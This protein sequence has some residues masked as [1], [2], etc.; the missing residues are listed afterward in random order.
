MQVVTHDLDP[1]LTFGDISWLAGLSKLPVLVKGV[2]RADD[3]RRCVEHGAAGIVVSNHGGRQL[4]DA[5]PTA[6]VL[7]RIADAIGGRAE[8][9]VDGGVRRGADVVKALALGAGAVLLGRPQLWAL[10]TGGE[11][12]VH[13]LLA[14]MQ[15]ELARAMALC[16]VAQVG[17]IDRSLLDPGGGL[18]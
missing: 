17:D 5:P 10:T 16:G 13:R 8:V 4:D 3:A 18:R 14:W 9:L 12:G 6:Q 1:A 7:P 15:G 11:A 2:L